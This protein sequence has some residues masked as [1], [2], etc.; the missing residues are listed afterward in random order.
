MQN[1]SESQMPYTKKNNKKREKV[2]EK[3]KLIVNCTPLGTHP[4]I[5]QKPNLNYDQ[6]AQAI[7]ARKRIPSVGYCTLYRQ[8]F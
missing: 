6:L 5:L 2:M 8:Y 7:A 3:H 1:E 4:N